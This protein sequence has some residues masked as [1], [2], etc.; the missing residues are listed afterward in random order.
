[1]SFHLQSERC[2]VQTSVAGLLRLS[3][4]FKTIR[5]GSFDRSA[6]QGG[7]KD[8]SFSLRI[9][10]P[11]HYHISPMEPP[12]VVAAFQALNFIFFFKFQV[13]SYSLATLRYSITLF[14]IKLL[15]IISIICRI[16]STPVE[17]F[18]IRQCFLP[19]TRIEFFLKL[20]L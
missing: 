11:H 9:A 7:S 12:R 17:I 19:F 16:L 5:S 20:S 1:M 10:D 8:P 18:Q 15:Q 2:R 3:R 14:K 13:L 6:I 4:L